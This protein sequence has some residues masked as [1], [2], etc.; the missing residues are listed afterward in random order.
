[1]LQATDV[2]HAWL[3]VAIRIANAMLQ[4]HWHS[5]ATDLRSKLALLAA[6]DTPEASWAA[7]HVLWELALRARG[8]QIDFRSVA[9][10][11]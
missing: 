2:H 9:Q 11:L 4:R 3:A 5:L 10:P 8:R 7:N 6:M 1:M